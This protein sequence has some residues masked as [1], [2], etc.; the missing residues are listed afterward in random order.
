M[1][2]TPG[3]AG[4]RDSTANEASAG[5]AG[6]RAAYSLRHTR[7]RHRAEQNLA[8]MRSATTKLPHSA[9]FSQCQLPQVGGSMYQWIP[10]S[11]RGRLWPQIE[12]SRAGWAVLVTS[13]LLRLRTYLSSRS[14]LDCNLRAGGKNGTC[15]NVTHHALPTSLDPRTTP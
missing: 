8:W 15:D 7:D 3:R 1:I 10:Y 6:H 9:K 13:G 5:E 12:H 14:P 4:Q 11:P 2:P